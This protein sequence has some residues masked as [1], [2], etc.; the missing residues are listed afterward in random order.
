MRP[1][2]KPVSQTSVTCSVL[3]WLRKTVYLTYEQFIL[4]LRNQRQLNGN[5]L[6]DKV[7]EYQRRLMI[8]NIQ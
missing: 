1:V 6:P 5:I 2:H 8:S 3:H 7:R 4:L